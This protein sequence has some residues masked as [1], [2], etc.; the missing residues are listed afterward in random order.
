MGQAMSGPP[1]RD[2]VPAVPP[3]TELHLAGNDERPRFAG[4]VL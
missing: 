3:G 4:A 2:L 1:W